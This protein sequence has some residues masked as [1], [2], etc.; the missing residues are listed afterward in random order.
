MTIFIRVAQQ[1]GHEDSGQNPA[2]AHV[3]AGKRLK[4]RD[5]SNLRCNKIPGTR[6][7]IGLRRFSVKH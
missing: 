2:L 1:F 3:L 5:S 7:G 6:A 4:T